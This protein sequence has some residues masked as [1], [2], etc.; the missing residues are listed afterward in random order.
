VSCARNLEERPILLAQRDFAV[1]EI[2]RHQRADE[3][4]PR[5]V[6]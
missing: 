3:V 2:P 4:L 6:E 1:I 5:F